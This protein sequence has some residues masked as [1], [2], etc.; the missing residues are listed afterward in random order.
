MKRWRRLG[1]IAF[2]SFGI[3]FTA[4]AYTHRQNPMLLHIFADSSCAC[5]DYDEEI[6]GLTLLNPFR[7]P[8]PEA[9]ANNFLE[10]IRQ[11]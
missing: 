6:S 5:S 7:N 10:D 9:S 1:I 2:V 8:S 3:I 4:L 11:G